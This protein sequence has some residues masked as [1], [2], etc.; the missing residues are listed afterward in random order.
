[1]IAIIDYGVGNL[2]SVQKAFE[3]L[4]YDAQIVTEQRELIRAH[5]IVVPGVGAFGDAMHA[6]ESSGFVEDLVQS[7]QAG[8]P[9][10][11]IC[12][13]MQ[14][15][16]AKSEEYGEHNGLALLE[17]VVTRL[18]N[19]HVKVPHVGWNQLHRQRQH[20]VLEGFEEG[21]NVYFVHS[22]AVVP[23]QPEVVIA[24]S[25]HGRVFPAIVGKDHVLGMQFHPEKSGRVGLTM[26]A[27]F[28]RLCQ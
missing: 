26:L 17:G 20:P 23:E 2:R 13:G 1:M 25:E 4:G 19:D 7:A 15:L 21:E 14:L 16:F 3:R 5:G 24:T 9:I 27:N 22:Y 11:G 28:A 8:K 10:L 18:P 6:L 12:L